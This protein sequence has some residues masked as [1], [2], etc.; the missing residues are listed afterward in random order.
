MHRPAYPAPFSRLF[1]A[2]LI[3]WFSM[4]GCGVWQGE[5]T[6][7]VVQA[8]HGDTIKVEKSPGRFVRVVLAG[9]DTP[10][11]GQPFRDTAR[12]FTLRMAGGKD[13]TI[14][15]T[16]RDGQGNLEAEVVLPN[17]KDLAR[18]L[19]D[20]GLV[21]VRPDADDPEL[22]RRQDRAR[23]AR[24]GLWSAP[25]PVPPWEYL[26]AKTWRDRPGS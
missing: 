25:D 26:H 3:A 23:R 13:V 10:Q 22:A 7:R 18:L 16:G 8:F 24:R 2:V 1:A 11:R 15:P 14:R 12:Q 9:I 17:G 6:G 20:A 19:V 4:A 21:W 5:F